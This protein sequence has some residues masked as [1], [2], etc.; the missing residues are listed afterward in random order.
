[1]SLKTKRMQKI[2]DPI[3][4]Q[5]NN[6]KHSIGNSKAGTSDVLNIKSV[7]CDQLRILAEKFENLSKDD[8]TDY[9]EMKTKIADTV[10]E[11]CLSNEFVANELVENIN[12][13]TSK[14]AIGTLLEKFAMALKALE[15]L[16]CLPLKQRLQDYF[17]YVKE[18]GTVN[19]IEDFQNIKELGTSIL[20][21]LGP[22][23]KYRKNLISNLLSER[24]ALYTFQIHTTF[25]MLVQLIQEQHQLNASI[26]NCKKYI[27][28]RMCLCFKLILEVLDA[29]NPSSEDETIEKENHFVYRMD[30]VLDIIAEMSTKTQEQQILECTE[31]WWGIEDIFSHAMSIAQMC[32]PQNFEAISAACQSIMGEYENLKSQLCSETPDPSVNNLFMNTLNDALYRLERKVNISVLMLVMEVFSDS[33]NALRKLVMTCGSSLTAKKRS[34]SDLHSAIE[35]FDQL[36]DKAMQIGIFANACCRDVERVNKIR[37]CLAGL[38]SLENELIAA[39]TAFYLHPDNKELR[40]SV[41]LLTSQ[42]QLEM[43]KLHN[44]VNLIIDSAAYCQ[45]VLDDLQERIR[46]MSDCFDNREAVTQQQVQ[47][48]VLR[49]VSLSSQLTIT[50]NDI[51][52]DNIDRQTIMMIRELK[53]AIFETDASAKKLLV[54]N[55]TEP[56]QLRVIKRCELILNVIKRLQPALVTVMNNSILISTNYGKASMG[57]GDMLHDS[58]LNYPSTVYRLPQDEKTLTYIRTPYTV[59]NYKPPLSIQPANSVPRTQANLSSLIP[60]IKAGRII[61]MEQTIMYKTPQ[62][63]IKDTEDHSTKKKLKSRNLFNIRQHLFSRES[64]MPQSE[65]NFSSE[66]IDLTDILEKVT[67][68]SETLTSSLSISCNTK[69]Q[70]INLPDEGKIR[71]LSDELCN[72][73]VSTI[74]SFK[75]LNKTAVK[76]KLEESS[77]IGG[78]DAPSIETEKYEDVQRLEKKMEILQKQVLKD[79]RE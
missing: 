60:Y 76:E 10:E 75:D 19:E 54:E 37:N 55:A 15:N 34:K 47:S 23:Q 59:Q 64:F 29:P 38:E 63:I 27:C 11:F 5:I 68:L 31:L 40:A 52:S 18:M 24:I 67:K 22:L 33:F 9:Q 1:M 70:Y 44:T 69:L 58:S 49:A 17:D 14:D 21:V 46:I 74:K 35:D 57:Q 2:L 53:A 32:Q 6:L 73:R 39:I 26:Y 48:I 62:K 4:I 50:V 30:L 71:T 43:N 66:T 16:E 78:G 36:T 13:H 8:I 25:S 72:I 79:S 56:Q 65:I 77:I 41:K 7:F 20:E 28:E 3:E 12:S 61:R 51:G 42:W 45:V